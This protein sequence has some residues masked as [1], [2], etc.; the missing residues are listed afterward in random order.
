MLDNAEA[1]LDNVLS[2]LRALIDDFNW[3]KKLNIRTAGSDYSERNDADYGYDPTPYS[4][5]H[6]LAESGYIRKEDV[7]VDF[8][9]GKGRVGFYLRI[10]NIF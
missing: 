2:I 4:V 6:R 3:D 8:G 5:L 10:P 1:M 7:L 9:C